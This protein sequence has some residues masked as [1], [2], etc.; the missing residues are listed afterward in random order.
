[1][2]LGEQTY[3]EHDHKIHMNNINY[4]RNKQAIGACLCVVFVELVKHKKMLRAC[5]VTAYNEKA[6]GMNKNKTQ[7]L[8][9]DH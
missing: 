5:I 1:M 3:A 4:Y 6:M 9:I 7:R 8:E 2:Y